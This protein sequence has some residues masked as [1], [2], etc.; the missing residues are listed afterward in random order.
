M[1]PGEEK[2]ADNQG[3][4][5]TANLPLLKEYQA[6]L[7]VEKGLRPLTCEAYLG[8]LRTFAGFAIGS[9]QAELPAGFLQVAVAGQAHAP[10]PDGE[11]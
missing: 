4:D 9:T 2:G 10:R 7:R 1:W 8:D 6:Y 5:S 3:V 11:Y